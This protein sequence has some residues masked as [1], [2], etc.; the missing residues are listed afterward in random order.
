MLLD[1][2]EA[3]IAVVGRRLTALGAS[4]GE[5]FDVEVSRAGAALARALKEISGELRQLERHD[6]HMTVTPEQRFTELL[7]YVRTLD[8]MQIDALAN[9]VNEL[10]SGRA[11]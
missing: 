9:V 7:K 11:A 4:G 10:Q 5:G 8:S 2:L 1:H 3:Q 6:R